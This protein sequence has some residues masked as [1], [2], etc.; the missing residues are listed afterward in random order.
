MTVLQLK[1]VFMTAESAV[2]TTQ[3]KLSLLDSSDLAYTRVGAILIMSSW[4]S[5][6]CTTFLSP[7]ISVLKSASCCVIL[8]FWEMLLFPAFAMH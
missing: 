2:D 7:M 6:L 1:R 4:W 5:Y 8:L 3:N